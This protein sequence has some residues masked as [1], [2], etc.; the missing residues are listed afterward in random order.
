MEELRREQVGAPLDE[1]DVHPDPLVQFARWFADAVARGVREPDACTLATVSATGAPAARTVALRGHD[2]RGFTFFT[3]HRSA[4]GHELASDPRAALVFHW[5]EVSRQ[6]RV[7][8]VVELLPAAE[9]DRYFAGRPLGSRLSAWASRQ[10]TVAGSRAAL[11]EAAAAAAARFGDAPPRPPFWGGY[12]LR[13]A[14]VELWQ[15]R[16]DRMHDRLRYRPAG[17]GWCLERLWP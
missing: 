17:D 9:S 11:E 15:G 2:G 14:E 16:P 12:L 7:A 5:R 4:K 8:G 6:V 13:P 1:A 10:S 3:N